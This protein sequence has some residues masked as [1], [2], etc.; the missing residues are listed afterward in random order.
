MGEMDR[1]EEGSSNGRVKKISKKK[2][3]AMDKEENIER[4]RAAAVAWG[5]PNES[6]V[7]CH[8]SHVTSHM[9]FLDKVVK[10]IGVGSVINGA[11]PV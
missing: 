6:C 8:M 7:K 1:A 9:F 5:S 4:Y 11:Y 2:K 10:L 3:L